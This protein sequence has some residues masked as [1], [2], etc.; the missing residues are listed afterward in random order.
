[1]KKT[2]ELDARKLLDEIRTYLISENVVASDIDNVLRDFIKQSIFNKFIDFSDEHNL[3]TGILITNDKKERRARLA[4]CYDL[5][6]SGG[7]YNITDGGYPK[8]F[9]RQDE[10]GRN[11]LISILATFFTTFERNY[12]AEIIPKIDIEEAIKSGEKNGNLKLSEI[13]RQR[14]KDF[15]RNQQEELVSFYEKYCR[16]YNNNRT[17]EYENRDSDEPR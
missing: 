5:D 13:T 1:M 9:L 4:P 7:V 11:T 8:F 17:S 16:N 2:D 10:N 15:F 6:F 3:N 14:Y 12:L